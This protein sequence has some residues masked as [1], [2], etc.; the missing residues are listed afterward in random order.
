MRIISKHKDYYDYLQGVYGIDELL[1]YDRRT[2]TLKT[3]EPPYYGNDYDKYT[4]AICNKLLTIYRYN[5]KFYHTIEELIELNDTLIKDGKKALLTSNKWGEEAPKN[6][7]E[8]IWKKENGITD[9]NKKLRQPV[10]MQL[11]FK[12]E[13]FGMPRLSDFGVAAYYPAE[14]IYQDIVA[15]IGWLVDNPPLPNTQTN[16]GK[17]ISHGFDLKQSFRHRINKK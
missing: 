8:M 3:I 17:I 16:E 13:D 6:D 10:L 7:A 1:T 5:N 14:Q 15:F 11:D 2:K 9:A 4:F 12:G